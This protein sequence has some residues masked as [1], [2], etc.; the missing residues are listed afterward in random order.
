MF[1]AQIDQSNIVVGITETTG[2]HDAPHM[3]E[4]ASF[5]LTLLGSTYANGVFTLPA[6]PV[7]TQRATKRAFQERFPKMPNGISTKWDAMCMFLNDDGYAA[8]LGVTS[9]TLYSLRML[10]T[11]G[12]QRM[13]ASPYVDMAPTGEAA[14]LLGLLMQASIPADFRF[15]SAERDTLLNAP[16]ADAERYTG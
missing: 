3:I 13:N 9:A 6:Q 10:I 7:L 2:V 15:S 12:T 1:C 8:S 4:I 14:G 11:T 16:L 5:D